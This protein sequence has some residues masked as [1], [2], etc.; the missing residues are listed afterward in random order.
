MNAIISKSAIKRR[1]YWVEEIRKLSGNFVDD[2]GRLSK[3]LTAEVNKGGIPTIIDHLRLCGSIPESYGHDS[4]EEKLYSKYTDCLLYLAFKAIGLKSLVLTERAD[5]ADVEAFAKNYSFVADAKAFRLSRTAKNQK[6]FKVQ[7]MHSWKRG[8]PNAMVVCP[9]YQLP[10]A[11]SQIYQS[12]TVNDVCVFTYS[13]LSLILNYSQIAGA[14]KAEELLH[15]IF[16]IVPMLTP[17]KN[18][19]D[20]WLA[21]NKTLLKFSKEIEELWQIEKKASTESI[22]IAKEEDL[23]YLALQREKIMR[24]DHEEALI[25][26]VRAYKIDS[27][28]KIISSIKDN[29]LFAIK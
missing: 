24:M 15:K 20:Y 3:E 25:E 13:H 6:D 23:T 19:I 28:I 2:Y 7:A 18:A 27:K 11:A 9:I 12:A 21:I 29:G 26:L 14:K 10:R 16:R 22:E 1:G 17:S 5:A 8:K 4:S